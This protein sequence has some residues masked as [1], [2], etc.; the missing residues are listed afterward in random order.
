MD[1]QRERSQTVV[2]GEEPRGESGEGGMCSCG[3]VRVSEE[4]YKASGE[5]GLGE[6]KG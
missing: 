2:E 3:G 4:T 6:E 1:Q 5:K